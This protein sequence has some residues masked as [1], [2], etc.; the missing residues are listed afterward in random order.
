[1]T[2]PRSSERDTGTMSDTPT[3][4]KDIVDCRGSGGWLS[5][6]SPVADCMKG[7]GYKVLMGE[8]GL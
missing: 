7:K 5:F 4:Q 3:M 2:A 6:G 1:M 8:S